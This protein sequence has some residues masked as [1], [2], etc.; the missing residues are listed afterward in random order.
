MTRALVNK[1]L[2]EPTTRLRE[3][4]S[5]GNAERYAETVR[6]LFDLDPPGNGDAGSN[7]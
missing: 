3:Q 4:A 2:H 5:N 7:E 1:L 6:D